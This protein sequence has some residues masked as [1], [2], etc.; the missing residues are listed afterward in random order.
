MHASRGVIELL[1]VF[2]H[3][4][5]LVDE[6]FQLNHRWFKSDKVLL[7]LPEFKNKKEIV[8]KMIE[9]ENLCETLAYGSQ[10]PLS[11]TEK[12]LRLFAEI[13]NSLNDIL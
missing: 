7:K 11:K 5:R 12:A 1:A 13:E 2:L 9:L 3:K 6:G 8:S 4:K 10:K